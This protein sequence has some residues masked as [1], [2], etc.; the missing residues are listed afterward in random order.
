MVSKFVRGD[1]EFEVSKILDSNEPG[2]KCCNVQKCP[3]QE[4][5]QITAAPTECN[6]VVAVAGTY[7]KKHLKDIFNVDI[8]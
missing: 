5:Y 6:W 2:D 4:L 1:M 8:G 3:E 7:C